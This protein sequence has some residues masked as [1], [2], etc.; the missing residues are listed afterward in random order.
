MSKDL[1]ITM[2]NKGETGDEILA[3][4]DAISSDSVEI[5]PTLDE[6]KF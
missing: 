1:M 2:L 6:I 3:I 4:L 5:A